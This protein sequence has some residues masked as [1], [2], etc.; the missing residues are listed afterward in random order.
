MH[1]KYGIMYHKFFVVLFN[2]I[3]LHLKEKLFFL[4]LSP[5]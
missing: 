4:N 3:T 2:I 1:Q 5:S